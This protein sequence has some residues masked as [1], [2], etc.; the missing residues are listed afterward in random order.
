MHEKGD[1][2][3]IPRL[4]SS[5]LRF[6]NERYRTMLEATLVF[7]LYPRIQQSASTLVHL[8]SGDAGAQRLQLT[9][10]LPHCIVCKVLNWP[11]ISRMR[12][13]SQP[14]KKFE[15]RPFSGGRR[16]RAGRVLSCS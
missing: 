15:G 9:W 13:T 10:P 5:T 14:H 4:S 6:R 1:M 7:A 11:S 2:R 12:S 8:M 16:L 3:T